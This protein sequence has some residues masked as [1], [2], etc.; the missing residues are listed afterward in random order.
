M[1]DAS[2]TIMKIAK[3]I[4]DT[5]HEPCALCFEKAEATIEA[6]MEPTNQ[7]LEDVGTMEGFDVEHT[8][9]DRVHKTWWRDMLTAA[10]QERVA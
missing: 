5:K 10:L 1:G 2:E 4:C 3:I 8:E 6:L 9:A 7:M